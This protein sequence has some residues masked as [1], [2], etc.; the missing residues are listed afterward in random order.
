MKI[1]VTG[2]AGFI[3]S[4]FIRYI[5]KKHLSSEVLNFDKLTYCGNLDNLKDIENYKRY[6]FFKG[7]ITNINDLEKAFKDFKPDYVVNFAAETHVDKSIHVGSGEFVNTNVLGVSNILRVIKEHKIKKYL[8]V[9]TDEVYGDLDINSNKKFKED[10]ALMP[11]SPYA[12]T[13]A[14]G[15]MLCRSYY[16]TWKIPIIVTRCGNNYGPYQYPEKFIPFFIFRILQNKK[17][18][19]Y[20]DGKNMRDWIHVI[21]HCRALDLCLFKGKQ[22]EIY[23]IGAGNEKN[24][25]EIAKMI[26]KYFNKNESYIEFVKDRPG[27]DRKYAI[28]SLKIKNELKWKP[29]FK[30]EKSFYET[31]EWYLENK[32]WIQNIKNKSNINNHNN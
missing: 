8:N 20:G 19:L 25:L 10:T 32:K 21:D 24:N 1:L 26:L 2:G 14:A 23:N 11:N 17:L 6:N 31:I 16:S 15:D 18:P 5:L 22:G 4:N 9:S 29:I 30:F 12:A 3:G 28:N 13:K 7:D 27:H